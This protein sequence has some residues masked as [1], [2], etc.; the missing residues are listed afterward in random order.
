VR[1]ESEEGLYFYV[2]IT[3]SNRTIGCGLLIHLCL[4]AHFHDLSCSQR[5]IMGG[6]LDELQ[7]ESRDGADGPP[8]SQSRGRSLNGE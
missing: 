3:E 8:I 4:E 7:K 2:I 6:S 5:D 1:S